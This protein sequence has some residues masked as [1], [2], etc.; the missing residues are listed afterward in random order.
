MARSCFDMTG[1]VR[2]E[3]QLFDDR[4]TILRTVSGTG[5]SEVQVCEVCQ[6]IPRGSVG[7]LRT[8]AEEL[9]HPA[10]TVEPPGGSSVLL[11]HQPIQVIFPELGRLRPSIAVPRPV[12]GALRSVYYGVS[13]RGLPYIALHIKFHLRT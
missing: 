6:E 10:G 5:G 8:V 13:P 9:S 7:R 4:G 3:S 2:P 1:R 12:V 11:P